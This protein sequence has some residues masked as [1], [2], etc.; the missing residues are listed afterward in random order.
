MKD[1]VLKKAGFT[2]ET[3]FINDFPNEN[4]N[5]DDQMFQYGD[6]N[7][8]AGYIDFPMKNAA[9]RRR[10]A[11]FPMTSKIPVIKRW[12]IKYKLIGESAKVIW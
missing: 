10:M 3:G 6:R 5:P 11:I 1:F 12:I 9:R 8:S 2:R 4:Q 7:E